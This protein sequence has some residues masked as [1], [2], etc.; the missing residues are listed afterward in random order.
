MSVQVMSAVL[1]CRDE[2]LEAAKRMVLIAIANYAGDD[3]RAWPSQERIAADSGIALR[4]CKRHIKWLEENGFLT[5]QTK[6]LGQGNGS[7]TT[8]C[9]LVKRL[10]ETPTD[11]P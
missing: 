11:T 6:H 4:T 5:R 3:G 9:V 8:Y 7:R 1:D 2:T 10:A